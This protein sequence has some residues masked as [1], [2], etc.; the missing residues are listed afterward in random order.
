VLRPAMVGITKGGPKQNN[1]AK[2]AEPA[3]DAQPAEEDATG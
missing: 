3:A 1:N 2:P